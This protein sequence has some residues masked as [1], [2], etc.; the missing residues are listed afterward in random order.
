MLSFD[1]KNPEFA[2]Q[3]EKQNKVFMTNTEESDKFWIAQLSNAY[4]AQDDRKESCKY[5]KNSLYDK[6]GKTVYYPMYNSK[7]PYYK[8]AIYKRGKSLRNGTTYDFQDVTNHK[9]SSELLDICHL[10][11]IMYA[12]EPK[13]EY[14]RYELSCDVWSWLSVNHSKIALPLKKIDT[15]IYDYDK[16]EEVLKNNANLNLCADAL[17]R[18][19]FN[20]IQYNMIYEINGNIYNDYEGGNIAANTFKAK[21]QYNCEYDMLHNSHG[22]ILS[23]ARDYVEINACDD[24]LYMKYY[25]NVNYYNNGTS[26]TKVHNNYNF[27][28]PNIEVVKAINRYESFNAHKTNLYSIVVKTD[29]LQKVKE[30]I[31]TNAGGESHFDETKSKLLNL[32]LNNIGLEI[33]N[34]V[35]SIAESLQPAHA[36][37]YSIYV[38]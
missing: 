27:C 18:D 8:S 9:L 15:F 14:G 19:T 38:K 12:I 5:N 28:Y 11:N 13:N 2:N 25:D 31:T 26:T 23:C 22:N 4:I 16:V 7:Q 20:S 33:A 35:R 17:I 21:N 10:D 1:Y 6:V 24:V 36:Q 3:H 37:L 34:G 30:Y 29:I 32:I